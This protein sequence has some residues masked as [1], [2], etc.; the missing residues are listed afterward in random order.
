MQWFRAEICKLT[1]EAFHIPQR[2]ATSFSLHRYLLYL[3]LILLAISDSQSANDQI[4]PLLR[5]FPLHIL[6]SLVEA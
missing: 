3:L 5:I 4:L 2:L 6:L 1:L